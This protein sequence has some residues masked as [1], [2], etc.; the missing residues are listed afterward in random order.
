MTKGINSQEI[1]ALQE[2]AQKNLE[3]VQ[4]ILGIESINDYEH[5]NELEV[6]AQIVCD[7]KDKIPIKKSTASQLAEQKR[8][9]TAKFAENQ[10]RFAQLRATFVSTL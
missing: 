1:K 5:E 6:E 7:H 3:V 10:A 8:F 2:L 9:L 4:K